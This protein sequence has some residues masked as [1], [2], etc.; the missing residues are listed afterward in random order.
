MSNSSFIQE[1]SDE[2]WVLPVRESRRRSA[3]PTE[4][5]LTLQSREIPTIMAC[6]STATKTSTRDEL[7]LT[8]TFLKAGGVDLKNVSLSQPTIFRQRKNKVASRAGEIKDKIKKFTKN[9]EGMFLVCHWDGKVIK[10]ITGKKEERLAIALSCPNEIPGQFLASP[11]VPDGK[12]KSM[13]K[14]VFDIG[15]EYGLISQMEAMV[16]DT[17]ASNTGVYKGS[18]SIFEKMIKK[19]LLWIACRHHVPEL[20]IKHASEV[21]RGPSKGPDDPLFKRFKEIFENL[22]IENRTTWEW[23]E[24]S[25]DWRHQRATAVLSWA[26]KHMQLAT[27]PREDYRELLELVVMFLGGV[28]K[29]V[30]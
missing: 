6:A 25:N 15:T 16:F 4:I 12:G 5:T 13:A 7:K 17:T 22:E 1:K 27:W 20:H 9:N 23:P 3:K 19:P 2:E 30:R 21:L 10:L 29:R 11:V 28:V 8:A 26:D 24:D 14:A 18:G